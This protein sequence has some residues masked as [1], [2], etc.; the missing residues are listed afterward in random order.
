[1]SMSDEPEAAK[2]QETSPKKQG[3]GKLVAIAIL[4]VLGGGGG[5]FWWLTRG[6]HAA[7]EKSPK[8]AEAESSGGGVV[9]LETFLVNLAD[10]SGSRYLKTT[11]KLVVPDEATAEKLT[12]NEV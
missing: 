7:E 3:K 9:A 2:P 1:M 10:T 4:L 6:A 8:K 5:A 12:K 11:L